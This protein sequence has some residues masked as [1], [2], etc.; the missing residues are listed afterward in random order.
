MSAVGVAHAHVVGSVMEIAAGTEA[1]I[2]IVTEADTEI[3]HVTM[4]AAVA[5]REIVTMLGTD[6]KGL[7]SE[8]FWCVHNIITRKF[9]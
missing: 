4:T 5:G 3:T 9:S 6:I 8:W 2:D 1:V 7:V